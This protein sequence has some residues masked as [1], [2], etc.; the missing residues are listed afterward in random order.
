MH[1][2]LGNGLI[3]SLEAKE[4]PYEVTDSELP[5]FVLRV[6]PTGSKTY[7]V[8]FRLKGGRRNR[9]R[10]GSANVLTSSQARD[11]AKLVL[12]EVANGKDPVEERRAACRHTLNSFLDELYAPW[13]TTHRKRGEQTVARLKACFPDF[14]NDRLNEI[15]PWK[16]EKWRVNRLENGRSPVTCNR[17]I[18]ALKAAL[19]KG[20]EW[21]FLKEHPLSKLRLQKVDGGNRVRYLSQDE[22]ARLLSA[23]DAREKH[24]REGRCRANEW[25]DKYDYEQLPDL[26][27]GRFVDHLKP[28]VLLSLNTGLR[29]G[30][31]F[32]LEWHDVDLDRAML[33]I[34]G[35][36]TKNG[37][38]RYV[39]LN[40]T[41]L[42]VLRDWQRQTSADGL[43]FKSRDGGRFNNV[44]MAWRNLLREA[45]IT[46]F[47][48]HDLR[49]QFASK[50][51][52]RGCD[53]N[54]VRELLGHSD[55]K[56]TM[57]YAHLAPKN[58]ADAV[59]LLVEMKSAH[60]ADGHVDIRSQLG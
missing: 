21:G 42:S 43:V 60:K 36:T 29:R 2:K 26:R 49:H 47:R 40:A 46:D 55:L 30:E 13:V 3:R 17:D 27:E 37:K 35:E 38:T 39:P 4:K 6:Q 1:A 51:V 31:L 15:S 48:W 8:A 57:I 56:M 41:A 52:M 58:L 9:V 33:T 50:L 11:K 10:L 54:V 22:E 5:G 28:M 19:S 25:R 34:R 24:L 45:S 53:L 18:A 7:Y 16:V 59:G 20:V 12:A 44:D 14:L 23:L 32:S